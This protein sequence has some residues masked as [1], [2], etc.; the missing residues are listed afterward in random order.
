MK[1]NDNEYLGKLLKEAYRINRK[2][3]GFDIKFKIELIYSRKEFDKKFGKKTPRW[4]CG[5]IKKNKII[6]FAP[7]VFE[8]KTIHKLSIYADTLIHELNHIFYEKLA[9]TYKPWWLHE[10]LA[11]NLEKKYK[12]KL[13]KINSSLLLDR[14]TFNIHKNFYS[15]SYLAV[16]ELLLKFGKSKLL[17]MIRVYSKKPTKENSYKLFIKPLLNLNKNVG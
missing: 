13:K 3:F 5:A 14:W 16:K 9:K 7:S 10:G 6:L 15:N 1:L 12:V 2:F 8:K 17:R 4:V 11:L